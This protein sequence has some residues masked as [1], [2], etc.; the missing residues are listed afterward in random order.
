M[1]WKI[2]CPLPSTSRKFEGRCETFGVNFRALARQYRSPIEKRTNSSSPGQ[3][4]CTHRHGPGVFPKVSHRSKVSWVGVYDR[5]QLWCR[6]TD[7]VTNT[8]HQNRGSMTSEALKNANYPPGRTITGKRLV[9]VHHIII[10]WSQ[11]QI[12]CQ[13][14]FRSKWNT[15]LPVSSGVS[16]SLPSSIVVLPSSES[17]ESMLYSFSNSKRSRGAGELFESSLSNVLMNGG[18][19]TSFERW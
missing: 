12:F 19:I 18:S 6:E 10:V 9:L 8:L 11:N 3:I 13:W 15:H 5:R 16:C 1:T 4:P 2:G 14:V 7:Q 17:S